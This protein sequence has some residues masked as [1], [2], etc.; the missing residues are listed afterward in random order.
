MNVTDD[1]I[2]G[3][4]AQ[5]GSEPYRSVAGIRRVL[6]V[7]ALAALAIVLAANWAGFGLRSDFSAM[8]LRAPFLFKVAGA[9]ALAAGAFLL[10]RRIALPA[11][12]TPAWYFLLPGIALFLLR[13]GLDPIWHPRAADVVPG[14]CTIEISLLALPALA[15]ILRALRN[16]APTRPTATG[17][18]AGV[19]AGAMGVIAHAMVCRNDSGISVAVWYGLGLV[20]MAGLGALLGR[21]LLRW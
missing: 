21:R 1:L 5:A 9:A 13:A 19:L 20:I 12:G 4:A 10:M 7:T 16:A 8:I 3:L 14:S 2:S 15:L 11:G 18:I 6:A 17:A